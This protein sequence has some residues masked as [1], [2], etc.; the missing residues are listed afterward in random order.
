MTRADDAILEFLLNDPNERL[1]AT[2]AF[3]ELNIEYGISTCRTRIRKLH[4]AGLVEYHDEERAAYKIT[5]K[6]E[7]YLSG[8][9]DA[10]D[11][12]DPMSDD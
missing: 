7:Q 8:Q 11:L 6:G 3:V 9:L 10:E 4:D 1:N 12:P 2:P 5:D